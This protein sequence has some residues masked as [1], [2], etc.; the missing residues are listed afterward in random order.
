MEDAGSQNA[1]ATAVAIIDA[2]D[3]VV[4]AVR[5]WRPSRSQSQDGHNSE[6][7]FHHIIYIVQKVFGPS[8]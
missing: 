4:A 2:V 7:D 1:V 8:L 3:A 5:L 6:S